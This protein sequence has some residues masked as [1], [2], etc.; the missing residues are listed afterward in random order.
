M[1]AVSHLIGWGFPLI[2]TSIPLVTGTVGDAGGFCWITGESVLGNVVR[3]AAHYIPVWICIV[4][5]AILYSV[6][7]IYVIIAQCRFA[8]LLHKHGRVQIFRN[9]IRTYI[10]LFAIPLSYL[11][12]YVF[13][14]YFRIHEWTFKEKPIVLLVLDA[15]TTSI[16]GLFNP[17]IYLVAATLSS[18]PAQKFFCHTSYGSL[19][20]SVTTRSSDSGKQE[21]DVNEIQNP[22]GDLGDSFE[23]TN[24]VRLQQVTVP[25]K[26]DDYYDDGEYCPGPSLF[27]L[28]Q[29]QA[30]QRRASVIQ[31]Q[32]PFGAMEREDA[33][34]IPLEYIE[35]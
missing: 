33:D 10:I 25:A 16:Q 29:Q 21:L 18:K 1:E 34:M 13:Q 7:L 2:L 35:M 14:T 9:S 32:G 12:S 6:T 31:L 24:R 17:L 15:M 26:T 20:S 4:L 8:R 11:M 22:W 23:V 3:F 30:K 19:I 27:D 28:E 5:M